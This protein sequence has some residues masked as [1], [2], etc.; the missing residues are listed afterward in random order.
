MLLLLIALGS[1]GAAVY[2]ISEVI[3]LPEQE[4]TGAMQRAATYGKPQRAAGPGDESLRSRALLPLKEKIARLVMR[5]NKKYTVDQIS[6]RLLSA[7]LGRRVSPMGFLA[8]K[9]VFAIGGVILGVV[10]G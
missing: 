5:V 8:T 10:M 6:L 2:F 1:L 9:G 4:R 7:G 3:T